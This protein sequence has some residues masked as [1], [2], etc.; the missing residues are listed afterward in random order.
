SDAMIVLEQESALGQE[1]ERAWSEA[2][3]HLDV[4]RRLGEEPPAREALFVEPAAWRAQP[5]RFPRIAL[6]PTETGVRFPI[7]L[8]EPVDRDIK[9]PR[10][11]VATEPPTGILCDNEGQ[12]EQ[13]AEPLAGH[14]ANVPLYSLDQLE[15]YRAA[16]DGDAPPPRLHRLGTTTWQR[17]RDKTRAAIRQMAIELL[18]LYARRQLA[19]GFAFPPDTPW[20]RELES[21]FLYEDT[22][23]QRRAS[24]EVKRDM[25]R[26]R[27]MDRLLVG[28]VGYGKTEVALRAAFKS[29]QAGKQVAVLVPTTILA[30]QHGRTFRERLA[31]YPVRIEVL[32]RFRGPKETKQVT[33][34]LETGEVDVVI[35][36]HRLLS[37]DVGFH[38]LGLLIVDE[39]HR[40]G[41]RHKERL[42]A[43][44]LAVDVLTLTA[45]PIPR[46]LHLSL[47]GLRDLTLL[48]TPPKDRS[49]VLTFI[50]P[51]DDALIEEALARASRRSP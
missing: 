37:R 14:R 51:W 18:E 42:K 40:F 17:Q 19:N 27:P 11:I 9:R 3:H 41:V 43:L 39:E 15:P 24:E 8:P 35:G 26:A 48:E 7:A 31:D 47:A 10:Q 4:A 16:A 12:L 36:T 20:Q 22:P 28:D 21:A 34:Q 30:E 32:S 38:D 25:E 1:V 44:K 23:D 29:V 6:D 33:R 46:T 2:A 50:E 13:L 5:A 49:P 45:T